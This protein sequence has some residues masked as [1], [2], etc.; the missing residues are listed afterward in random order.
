VPIIFLNP[1]GGLLVLLLALPL[2]AFARLRGRDAAVRATLRLPE[3][4]RRTLLAPVSAALIGGALLTLAAT[5]PAL[6]RSSSRPQRTDA[7]TLF[8]LDISRSMLASSTAGSATRLVRA[9]GI[10]DRLRA[11][12]PAVPAGIASITDRV[13][14]Y[15]LATS[16]ARV[17]ASTLSGAVAVDQPPPTNIYYDRATD[18]GALADIPARQF[19]SAGVRKRVV[20][21]LTDGESRKV[22]ARRMQSLSTHGLRVVFVHVWQ[23]DDRVFATGRPDKTY[24]ADPGSSEFLANLAD[25][26][27]ASA[28]EERV[29]QG[30][31]TNVRAAAGSGPTEPVR[32]HSYVGLMRPISIAALL[33]LLFVLW[34]RNAWVL[35]RSY[36]LASE[37]RKAW[38]ASRQ[39]LQP[40]SA[41]PHQLLP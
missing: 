19:F 41:Q 33:P 30:A 38:L 36:T 17:F 40:S 24:N 18:L 1:W 16:D 11:A 22:P 25:E 31:I 28:T 35:R 32:D 10:A 14:P 4:S 2:F 8:V 39:Q 15:V 6:V 20:I 5:Q 27:G 34:L 12:V 9:K 13:L 3:P 29:I 7:E 21:V 26:A 23:P 37:R